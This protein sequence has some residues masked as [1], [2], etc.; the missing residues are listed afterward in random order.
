MDRSKNQNYDLGYWINL[1]YVDLRY[2]HR[3]IGMQTRIWI[4]FKK[5]NEDTRACLIMLDGIE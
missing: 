4:L 3:Y 2:L 5:N 1:N